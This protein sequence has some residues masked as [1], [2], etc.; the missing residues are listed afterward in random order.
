[1]AVGGLYNVATTPCALEFH[2][3]LLILLLLAE[4]SRLF[5]SRKM[6]HL[7]KKRK[8]SITGPETHAHGHRRGCDPPTLHILGPTEL[9][10]FYIQIH[11]SPLSTRVPFTLV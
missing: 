1:M 3:V 5:S 11:P 8:R 6:L 4:L 10:I 9:C 2:F 7:K